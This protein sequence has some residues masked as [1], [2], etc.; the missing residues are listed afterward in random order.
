MLLPPAAKACKPAEF[1]CLSI[2]MRR[3][4]VPQCEGRIFNATGCVARQADSLGTVERIDGFNQ[5]DG[6]D[7]DQVVLFG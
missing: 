2:L 3:M 7:G 5:P 6:A 4:R 1:S